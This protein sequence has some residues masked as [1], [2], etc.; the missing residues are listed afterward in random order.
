MG[1]IKVSFHQVYI[2]SV[3]SVQSMIQRRSIDSEG[4]PDPRIR[5]FEQTAV[6]LCGTPDPQIHS[7]L[8][9]PKRVPILL[10]KVNEIIWIIVTFQS[11]VNFPSQGPE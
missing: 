3:F 6:D 2:Q 1:A 5:G 4:F 9:L 8:S 10:K 11:E 7:P